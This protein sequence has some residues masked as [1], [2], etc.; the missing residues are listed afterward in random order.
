MFSGIGFCFLPCSA[1]KP[2][3]RAWNEADKEHPEK[4]LPSSRKK[5]NDKQAIIGEAGAHQSICKLHCKETVD[6]DGRD[7]P[8]KSDSVA[9]A[10]IR[11]V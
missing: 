8:K 2:R 4:P 1:K 11:G 5:A 3:R 6:K 7:P 9:I 10:V